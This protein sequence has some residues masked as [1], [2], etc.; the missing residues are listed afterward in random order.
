MDRSR[1]VTLVA[2][3]YT[4][5]SIGQ[6][7][8]TETTRT[9][10]ANIRSASRAEWAAAGQLG[11]QPELVVTCFSPDYE[12]GHERTVIVDS[13]RYEV[14]RTYQASGEMTELYL[15]REVGG[16]GQEGQSAGAGH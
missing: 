7:L 13:R 16:H 6:L 2:K 14:Y 1:E 8:P 9:I 4:P 10:Y 5:D 15:R 3:A 12:E 11:F